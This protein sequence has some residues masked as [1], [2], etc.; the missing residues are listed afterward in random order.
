MLGVIL[1]WTG[2]LLIF[3]ALGYLIIG[4]IRKNVPTQRILTLVISGIIALIL[5]G[6]LF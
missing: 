3:T 1:Y 5:R 4:L 2:V 6:F